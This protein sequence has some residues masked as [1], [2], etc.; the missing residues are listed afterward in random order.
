MPKIVLKTEIFST[1]EICFDLS[2]SIDLHKI[3][4][5]K[6]N[7]KAIEGT[8][9][10]LI[11]L[12]ET[13]TWQATHFG[14]NQKLTPKITAFDKPHYFRD[15]QIKGVFKSIYHEHKFKQLENKVLMVDVFEFQ[16]PFGVLGN[17]INQLIL[18]KY[19]RNLLT[20]RNKVIKEFAETDKWK[21]ILNG[22]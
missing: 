18:T 14:I 6:T 15:E 21:I 8:I 3:S 5:A 1:I 7:E 12:N 11:N 13:V 10:G 4:T 19:L 16:S 9:F 17:I 20:D 22:R 2:R